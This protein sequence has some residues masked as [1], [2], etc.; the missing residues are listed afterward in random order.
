MSTWYEA[1]LRGYQAVGALN[2]IERLTPLLAKLREA[3]T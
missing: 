1:A 3:L 2:E